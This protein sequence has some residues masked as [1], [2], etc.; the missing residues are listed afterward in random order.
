MAVW[1]SGLN[2]RC[3]FYIIAKLHQHIVALQMSEATAVRKLEVSQNKVDVCLVLTD[4]A[5]HLSPLN[6]SLIQWLLW[7]CIK[8][9]HIPIMLKV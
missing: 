5:V 9:V 8:H 6:C 4:K 3:L 2:S 1:W 7:P